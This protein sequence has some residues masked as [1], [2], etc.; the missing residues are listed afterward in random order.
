MDEPLSNLDAS[1]RVKT[2]T[3]I[4]RLQR[5]LTSASSS[6]IRALA[7]YNIALARLAQTEG[8]TLERRRV[9]MSFQ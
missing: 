5:D 4:K 3:E 8:S 1:L 7:D 6:E 2:R 9:N